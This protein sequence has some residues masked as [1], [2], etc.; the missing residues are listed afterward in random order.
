[1][2]LDVGYYHEPEVGCFTLRMRVHKRE[3]YPTTHIFSQV[4]EI[5]TVGP[6]GVS[7]RLEFKGLSEQKCK[8]IKDLVVGDIALLLE[9]W[10][11]VNVPD[12]EF[13]HI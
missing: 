3:D 12:S 9:A 5:W 2:I 13:I 6:K 8:V 10:R 11:D 7:D 4:G 1:M